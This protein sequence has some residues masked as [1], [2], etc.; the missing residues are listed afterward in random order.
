MRRQAV[1][2]SSSASRHTADWRGLVP[3]ATNAATVIATRCTP[4]SSMISAGAQ[5]CS[6]AKLAYND[7]SLF[8]DTIA[9]YTVKYIALKF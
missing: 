1:P 3:M 6:W 5:I 9:T 7:H 2:P 8:S 4:R